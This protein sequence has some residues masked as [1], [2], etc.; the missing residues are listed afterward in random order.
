[1]LVAIIGLGIASCSKTDDDRQYLN[2]GPDPKVE[3]DHS[4][5][6]PVEDE[7]RFTE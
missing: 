7:I 4:N 6:I 2:E 1:M 3:T 5:D